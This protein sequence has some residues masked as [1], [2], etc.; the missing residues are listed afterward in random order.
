M[1]TVTIYS[2]HGRAKVCAEH[3]EGKTA[4]YRLITHVK[5]QLKQVAVRMQGHARVG[6]VVRNT[7]EPGQSARWL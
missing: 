2:N 3:T 4:G 1:V 6:T 7:V 5:T